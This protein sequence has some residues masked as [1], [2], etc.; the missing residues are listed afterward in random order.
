[1]LRNPKTFKKYHEADE[2]HDASSATSS[3]PLCNIGLNLRVSGNG[4]FAVMSI[5]FIKS[6]LVYISD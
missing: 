6:I 5:N 3:T 4:T 1:M 2:T